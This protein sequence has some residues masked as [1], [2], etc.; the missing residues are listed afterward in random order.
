M[1]FDVLKKYSVTGGYWI[2]SV[3]GYAVGLLCAMIAAFV[4]GVAQPALLYLVPG[5]FIPV[6]LLGYKR[7]ELRELW[8]GAGLQEDASKDSN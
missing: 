7:S 6:I 8:T 5:C 2:V 1:R 3:I 4:Y